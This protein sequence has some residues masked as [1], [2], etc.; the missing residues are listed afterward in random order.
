MAENR[1]TQLTVEAVVAPEPAARVTQFVVETIV[2][3]HPPARVTQLV[4]E[5]VRQN[6]PDD[7]QPPRT[8]RA[9]FVG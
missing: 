1:V 9:S 5:T 3:Q 2:L 4:V 8:S 6:T 7:T